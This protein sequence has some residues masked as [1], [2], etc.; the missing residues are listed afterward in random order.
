MNPHFSLWLAEGLSEEMLNHQISKSF[1]EKKK[2]QNLKTKKQKQKTSSQLP[3]RSCLLTISSFQRTAS[4]INKKNME[5][6]PVRTGT[7]AQITS[8][9]AKGCARA[10][11][12][13][14]TLI[15]DASVKDEKC[16]CTSILPE[17]NSLPLKMHGWKMKTFLLGQFGPIFRGKL[18]LSFRECTCTW[19]FGFTFCPGCQSQLKPRKSTVDQTIP[20]WSAWKDDPWVARILP[21][22][23]SL[24]VDLDFLENY[25]QVITV[26][27]YICTIVVCILYTYVTY[28]PI[29]CG[30]SMKYGWIAGWT[31]ITCQYC[32][33][34]SYSRSACAYVSVFW[35]YT[36]FVHLVHH[37]WLSNHDAYVPL[38][39]L[40]PSA[41]KMPQS[42]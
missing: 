17:T 29:C 14:S 1:E 21:A 27:T 35:W 26:I 25:I 20:G 11:R 2:G 15:W 40:L 6:W 39:I 42:F 38:F 28:V 16:V 34:W 8:D 32:R 13:A 22:G 4:P 12:W 24:L 36:Y 41:T 18:A 37:T 33:V 31:D 10:R 7:S 9:V 3:N 19:W 30:Y 5:N 23:A